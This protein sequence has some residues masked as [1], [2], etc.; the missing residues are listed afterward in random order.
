MTH[1]HL[2]DLPTLRLSYLITGALMKNINIQL[3]QLKPNSLSN[4]CQCPA[5][6]KAQNTHAVESDTITTIVDCKAFIQIK[7]VY[8]RNASEYA[9]F[10]A[11][12]SI[13]KTV[14]K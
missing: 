4:T 2:N 11:I 7:A 13:S 6:T 12:N 3:T 1:C 5:H 8:S 10:L 14:G 9:H